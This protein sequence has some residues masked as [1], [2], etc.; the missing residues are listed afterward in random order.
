MYTLGIQIAFNTMRLCKSS[1]E[2]SK[3]RKKKAGLRI[4]SWSFLTFPNL[5]EKE[6]IAKEMEVVRS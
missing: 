4:A 6:R 3:E 1:K 2:V 5:G